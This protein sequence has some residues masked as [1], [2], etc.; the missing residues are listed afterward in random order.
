MLTI[1]IINIILSSAEATFQK[2]QER[3]DFWK[4]SKPC[5]VGIH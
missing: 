5:H 1:V 4:P 2:S 3:K